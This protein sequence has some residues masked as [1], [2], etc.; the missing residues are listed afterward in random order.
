MIFKKMILKNND[1]DISEKN[2]DINN[3]DNSLKSS[4]N[5]SSSKLVSRKSLVGEIRYVAPEILFKRNNL[6]Y[7]YKVDIFSLGFTMYSLMN[8]SNNANANLPKITQR[9]NFD[10]T[11]ADQN[12][13]NKFYSQKLIEFVK[14]L[15]EDDQDKRP[16]ASEA[17]NQLKNIQL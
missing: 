8:P 7:D 11:R 3:R 9:S 2:D 10:F 17:L 1:D 13:E 5:I 14:L 12:L 6:N 4:S 16:T 15:Y